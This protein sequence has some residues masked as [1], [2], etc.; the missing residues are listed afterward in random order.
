MSENLHEQARQLIS[1]SQVDRVSPADSKWLEAHLSACPECAEWAAA[2]HRAVQAIRLVSV[3]VDPI[4]V[5]RTR[6]RVRHRAEKM[7]GRNLPGIWLWVGAALSWGWIAASASYLWGC[8]GLLAHRIGIPSPIW[9]MGFVLWWMVPA[10]AVAVVLSMR[11]LQDAGPL[12][13]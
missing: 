13:E 3:R 4:L 8:F 10:L 1:R 5:E 9:Q 2:T 11:S 6:L 7:A 12:S